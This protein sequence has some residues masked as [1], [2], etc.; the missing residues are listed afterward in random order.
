MSD[1]D[2]AKFQTKVGNAMVQITDSL[3]NV[4]GQGNI[5]SPEFVNAATSMGALA[6][7]A[8][9]QDKWNIVQ[10]SSGINCKRRS[11]YLVDT[12]TPI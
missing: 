11:G 4:I 10:S 8:A 2:Y 6:Y 3:T 9:N 1:A 5:F 7:L 12:G